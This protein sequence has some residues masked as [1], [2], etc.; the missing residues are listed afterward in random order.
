MQMTSSNLVRTGTRMLRHLTGMI[1]HSSSKLLCGLISN[2]RRFLS[3]PLRHDA[4]QAKEDAEAAKR[5]A[6]VLEELKLAQEASYDAWSWISR[7]TSLFE[8]H[9]GSLKIRSGFMSLPD[10]ILS[11]VLV[12]ASRQKDDENDA[13]A[14]KHTANEVVKLSHVCSRF[15]SV[16]LSTVELWNRVSSSMHPD[17]ISACLERCG[18]SGAAIITR[19]SPG[20]DSIFHFARIAGSTHLWNNFKLACHDPHSLVHDL[21]RLRDQT[22]GANTP[23]LKLLVIY[24]PYQALV[25]EI[26][27]GRDKEALNFYSTWSSPEL[28]SMFCRNFV[29]APFSGTTNITYLSIQLAFHNHE[30]DICPFN[31]TT[32]ATFL[33]SCQALSDFSMKISACTSFIAPPPSWTAVTSHVTEMGLYFMHCSDTIVTSFLNAVS[34]SDVQALRLSCNSRKLEDPDSDIHCRRVLEAAFPRKDTYP[35]L[36]N[37]EL[38]IC[39]EGP[40]DA[41]AMAFAPTNPV[42][43][44]FA[45]IS[46]IESLVLTTWETV[47]DPVPDNIDMPNLKYLHILNC[48]AMKGYWFASLL[49]GITSSPHRL[50]G[51][52]VR[53]VIVGTCWDELVTVML[54]NATSG[55]RPSTDLA[56]SD[57]DV[58][59]V[60]HTLGTGQGTA[61]TLTDDFESNSERNYIIRSTKHVRRGAQANS[62]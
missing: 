34:F 62:S 54:R 57:F 43:I 59:E 45:N 15:R 36:R 30:D 25:N 27:N 51:K 23:L 21:Y 55:S 5:A 16:I 17:A 7:K 9:V 35:K 41:Q 10:E 18:P 47:L 58:T 44:P 49:K 42:F 6:I 20:A 26:C 4:L 53:L 1:Q 31:A 40:Y 32:T 46:H 12:S 14:V 28:Q 13:D 56:E 3:I 38:V 61:A 52:P 19:L 60:T 24:Y 37:L 50:T 11:A 8:A 33:S 22:V 2:S 48:W 29:P 39:G